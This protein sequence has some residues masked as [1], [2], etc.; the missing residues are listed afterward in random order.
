[1]NPVLVDDEERQTNN[2]A[3][4][5][6]AII[7]LRLL[8][9]V[10]ANVCVE[11]DPEYVYLG[12]TGRAEKRRSQGWRGSNGLL[13]NVHLWVELLEFIGGICALLLDYVP[14][15]E[16]PSTPLRNALRIR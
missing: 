15:E 16:P 5:L 4:L 1:M 8:N 14:P 12:A 7:G 11:T 10:L 6:A 2:A 13:S 3:E 9:T